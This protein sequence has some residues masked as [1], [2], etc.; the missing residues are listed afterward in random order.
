VVQAE[1]NG[2]G[3]GALRVTMVHAYRPVDVSAWADNRAV[4]SA[5]DLGAGALNIWGNSLPAEHLPAP[6]ELIGRDAVPFLLMAAGAIGD[7][8][9]C[10]GQYVTIPCGRYDWVHLLAAAERRTED[11]IAM[12]FASGAVDFEPLRVSDFWTG[13]PA[14]FGERP[15]LTTPVLH[16]RRHVQQQMPAQLWSQR[17]AVTRRDD[18]VGLRLPH[19]VAIHVFALTLQMVGEERR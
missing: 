1:A 13:A 14:W 19:N 11:S 17:V 16:Y 3:V 7:N 10:A 9:R 18:L 5:G 6:G 4:S 15:A 12:H 2:V 8:L